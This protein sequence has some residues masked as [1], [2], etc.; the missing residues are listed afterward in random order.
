M[1]WSNNSIIPNLKTKSC[2]EINDKD[3]QRTLP[4][5]HDV[6][7]K[8]SRTILDLSSVKLSTSYQSISLP[9]IDTDLT[10]SVK[11]I[12]LNNVRSIHSKKTNRQCLFQSPSHSTYSTRKSQIILHPKTKSAPASTSTSKIT[13]DE[14]K[15]DEDPIFKSIPSSFK[16]QRRHL[17]D[18]EKATVS[19]RK[20]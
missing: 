12:D 5:T 19:K 14:S 20:G 4:N 6:I 18:Q 2:N 9:R 13:I 17:Q 1:N 8:Q 10:N 11:S 16:I 7:F 3:Y 15:Q